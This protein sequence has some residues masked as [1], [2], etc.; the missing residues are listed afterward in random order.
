[1][2]QELV[3]CPVPAAGKQAVSSPLWGGCPDA[4]PHLQCSVV[5]LLPV[6]R[7]LPLPLG[8]DGGWGDRSALKAPSCYDLIK[9]PPLGWL[10]HFCTHSSRVGPSV[11]TVMS[12]YFLYESPLGVAPQA[13][14]LRGMP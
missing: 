3:W 9:C 10:L 7:L 6:L 12:P 4:A 2:G 8:G 14:E 5:E 1:M 11:H 13:K